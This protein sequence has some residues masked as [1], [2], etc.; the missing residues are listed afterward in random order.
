MDITYII[1]YIYLII[2]L[3]VFYYLYFKIVFGEATTNI[4]ETTITLDEREM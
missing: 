4:D 2:L 1:L 3:I